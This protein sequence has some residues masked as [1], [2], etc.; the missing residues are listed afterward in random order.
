M[1][2]ERVYVLAA[3]QGKKVGQQLLNKALEIANQK[4]MESIWL[5][6]WE[7]NPDAVRFYKANGYLEAGKHVFYLGSD[8]QQDVIMKLELNKD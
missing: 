6:V 8:K 7:E 2:I 4:N 1:E 3:F 5:G